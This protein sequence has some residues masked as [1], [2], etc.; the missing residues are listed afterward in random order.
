VLGAQRRSRAFYGKCQI[1]GGSRASHDS[2]SESYRER[3]VGNQRTI[4]NGS[5]K[6]SKGIIGKGKYFMET[7]GQGRSLGE[8]TGDNERGD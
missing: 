8:D 1:K 2:K 5:A 7:F 3:A 6:K 4:P